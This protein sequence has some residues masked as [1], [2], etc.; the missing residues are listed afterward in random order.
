MK[1]TLWFGL[2]LL[3]FFLFLLVIDSVSA[4]TFGSLDESD[5]GDIYFC[6]R[7]TGI[8]MVS[9][10][11][12]PDNDGTST[13][14]YARVKSLSGYTAFTSCALYD[15]D[16]NS[17]IATTNARSISGSNSSYY[18]QWYPFSTPQNV[19]ST[20][21]Y[22]ITIF[23]AYDVGA[24]SGDYISISYANTPDIDSYRDYNVGYPTFPDPLVIGVTD[25][26]KSISI[27]C[28][29]TPGGGAAN[30]IPTVDCV[31]PENESVGYNL[32]GYCG[33]W[34][35]D[36][37]GN[38][39]NITWRTNV[40]GSWNTVANNASVSPNATYYFY[41]PDFNEY[42]AQYW[43]EIYCDDGTDNISKRFWYET[44]IN[45]PPEFS[46]LDP[47]DEETGVAVD[48]GAIW[49][50]I[51]DPEGDTFSFKWAC[52]DGSSNSAIGNTNGTKIL[53]FDHG[54]LLCGTVYYWWINATDEHGA[55]T[56]TTFSFTTEACPNNLPVICCESPVNES[57]NDSIEYLR[58]WVNVSD[59]DDNTLNVSW[60][61]NATGSWVCY[62][63][64]VSV[65]S[66][67]NIS[68]FFGNGS[69]YNTSFWWSV[70]VSDGVGGWS[71]ET[72]Y[73]STAN[74]SVSVTECPECP[75]CEE[76]ERNIAPMLIFGII[77]FIIGIYYYKRKKHDGKG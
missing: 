61:S 56:N 9:P 46:N 62:G 8:V 52:T 18:W 35:N 76:T 53:M 34:V 65:V 51:N 26:D 15:T 13:G 6:G 16:D 66:G 58:T 1:K 28:T 43:W 70:N 68:Q 36:T 24:P 72:F 27:Y 20:K 22:Y 33:I 10:I 17:L 44:E 59:A 74:S 69:F 47:A 71:N 50:D 32:S 77:C 30:N 37:D 14:I 25:S 49:V 64:N 21:T 4:E 48:V 41:Y 75:E 67:T 63:W 23:G 31:I 11:V 5:D 55:Y 73:F 38:L 42:N 19:Y 40:S 7:Y 12:S 45:I 57:V 3:I 29:Y 2:M 54:D 60:W 39:L